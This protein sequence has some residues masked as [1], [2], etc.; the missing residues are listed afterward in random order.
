MGVAP[1]ANDILG[2]ADPRWMGQAP[3]WF[4]VLKESELLG[5]Q[6]LGPVGGRI[7]A[8]VLL[9]LLTVDSTSYF[10]AAIPWAPAGLSFA[11][12]DLLRLAGAA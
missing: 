7:V 12:G 5:G 11:M 6:R 9:G 1:L 8:E 4:Y 10:N 3:L 2:L